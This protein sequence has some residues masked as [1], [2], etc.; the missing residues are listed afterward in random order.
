M[1]PHYHSAITSELKR[2]KTTLQKR[3]VRTERVARRPQFKPEGGRRR[4]DLQD[5]SYT[6]LQLIEGQAA[7][8]SRVTAPTMR[9]FGAGCVRLGGKRLTQIEVAIRLHVPQ[10]FISK[11]ESS[12]RR[13]AAVEVQYFAYLYKKPLSYFDVL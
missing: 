3:E 6:G 13:V 8:E 11:C 2:K 7:E 9:S 5:R 12:E 1:F 4:R 10:S